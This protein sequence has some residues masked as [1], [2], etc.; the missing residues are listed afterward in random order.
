MP[1]LDRIFKH[2]DYPH[3][4]STLPANRYE[5]F[6]ASGAI[7]VC[8]RSGTLKAEIPYADAKSGGMG[9]DP[10]AIYKPSS[11]QSVSAAK[12]MGSFTGWTHAAVNAIASEVANIQL[13]LYKINGEDHEEQTDHPL[14]TLLDTV[15]EPTTGIG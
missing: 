4:T 15:S 3:G 5:G 13:R 10:M 11:A 12:A 9:A 8:D 7:A 6:T 2:T 14:L 1:W